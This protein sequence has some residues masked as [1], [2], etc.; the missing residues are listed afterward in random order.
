MNN[1]HD[2][3]VTFVLVGGLFVALGVWAV[4]NIW[5]DSII[6]GGLERVVFSI[7]ALGIACAV[8]LIASLG[9]ATFIGSTAD[10][11]IV[12][13]AGHVAPLVSMRSADGIS[14]SLRGG[15]FVMSGTIGTEQYYFWYEQDGK[16]IVPRKVHAGGGVYVFEE[17]RKDAV[18]KVFD[19]S[20]THAWVSWFGVKD[21][22][23]T[24]EFH[25]PVGTVQKQLSVQ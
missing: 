21:S 8:G 5:H 13:P 12:N 4:W 6:D 11:S 16:A 23:K 22:G 1:D 9:V 25:V 2:G 20:F 10:E 17:D 19:W 14:G 15:L 7:G 18:V 24:W 3:I